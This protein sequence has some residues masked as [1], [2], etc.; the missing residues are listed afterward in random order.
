MDSTLKVLKTFIESA[1]QGPAQK[2]QEWYAIKAKTIGGSEI[3]TVLELNPYKKRKVLIAEKLGIGYKFDGNIATRWGNI[4]EDAT[5]VFIQKVLQMEEEIIELGSIE[6]PIER[7][8]YSPDGLGIVKL[9]NANDEPEYYIILFEFKAPYKSI[10]DGTIPSHYLP[11]VK[12]GLMSIPI[13]D[14]AIFVNNVYRKC[15]LNNLDFTLKYDTEFHAKTNFSSVYACGIVYFYQTDGQYQEA[16]KMCGFDDVSDNDSDND[17]DNKSGNG[18]VTDNK[19]YISPND[20]DTDILVKSAED[21]IDFGASSLTIIDRLFEL[22]EKKKILMRH[23]SIVLN[24]RAINEID[25]VKTHGKMVEDIKTNPRKKLTEELMN[26]SE[27]CEEKNLVFIGYLP[28]KLM[29]TDILEEL[30]DE[31]WLHEIKEPVL[32]TLAVID[33]ISSHPDPRERYYELY[34]NKKIND[35]QL[36]V[37]TGLSEETDSECDDD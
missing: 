31:D 12:T 32:E 2:S 34:P 24:H 18:I 14:M 17:S 10:P 15:S 36:T 28:W 25:F 23:S 22:Y 11:Q 16:K 21:L 4:F 1:A 9:L 8:R 6:G 20:H 26:F 5:R 29:Q 19:V 27:E 7:Q 37:H 33:E 3:A 30:P 35:E 13:A